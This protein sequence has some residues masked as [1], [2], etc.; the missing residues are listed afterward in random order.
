MNLRNAVLAGL[1]LAP[2]V[3]V[4]S[5]TVPPP[6]ALPA[7]E[8][9]TYGLE[10]KLIRAGIAQVKWY[11][12]GGGW[13]ADLHLESAGLVSKL[14]KVDDN[15]S[16]T[17]NDQLCAQTTYMKAFEGKRQRE[18]KVSFDYTA[19][20]VSYLERDLLKNSTVLA[21]DTEIPACV[22]DVIGA[23]VKLRTMR[24]D[25]GQSVQIPMSDGKKFVNARLEAQEREEVK[26]PAGTYKTIRY[27]AYI[28][29]DVLYSKKG[30][31]FVWMTDDAR[32]LPVQMQIRMRLLVGTITLQLEKEERN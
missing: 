3:P 16:V 25:P 6:I 2:A 5:E 12:A 18:T 30:R 17:L 26:T 7:N 1:L 15:Y 29:N 24:V 9:L 22:H 31:V 20:K 28:M 4:Y 19:K 11:S 27:E 8:T 14:Y 21:K 13:Q 23:L 10:W 32:R